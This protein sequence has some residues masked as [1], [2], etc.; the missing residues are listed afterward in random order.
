MFIFIDFII[1]LNLP[2]ISELPRISYYLNMLYSHDYFAQEIQ[3]ALYRCKPL[4]LHLN[5]KQFGFLTFLQAT[6]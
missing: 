2:R 5:V 1:I 3:S 6:F 4:C